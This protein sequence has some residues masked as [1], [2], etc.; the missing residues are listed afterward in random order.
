MIVTSIRLVVVCLTPALLACAPETGRPS[1][2]RDHVK[3]QSQDSDQK[4][5]E[6]NAVKVHYLEIVTDKVD[7]RDLAVAAVWFWRQEPDLYP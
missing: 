6:E 2:E 7:D 3:T 4:P 5:V 1:T